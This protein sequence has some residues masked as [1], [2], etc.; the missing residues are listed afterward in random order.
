MAQASQARGEAVAQM[1]ADGVEYEERM[2]L[3]EDITYPRPL[4]A[5][6]T[7]RSSPRWTSTPPTPPAS[8]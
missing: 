1:K 4:A 8:R 6:T 2:R 7:G 5:T 3:L